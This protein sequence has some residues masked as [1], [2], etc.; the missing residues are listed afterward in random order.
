APFPAPATTVTSHVP[1]C[2]ADPQK[3]GACAG[4]GAFV[5]L[6]L[7]L[8]QGHVAASRAACLQPDAPAPCLPATRFRN[9]LIMDGTY[10]SDDAAVEAPLTQMFDD[11]V[12]T[13]VIGLGELAAEP[14]AV[15]QLTM[16]AA[17]GS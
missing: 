11:G 3:P 5:H 4:S 9:V 7:E 8:V 1:R 12:I 16:M 14:E 6:G 15:E 10:D 17:W 13:Y 2:D